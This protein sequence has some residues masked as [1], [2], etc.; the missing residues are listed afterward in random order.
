[1]T[2]KPMP[3]YIL[4]RCN[5]EEQK[6]RKEKKGMFYTA[7]DHQYMVYNMEWGEILAVGERAAKIFPYAKPGM[8][9][10]MHHFVQGKDKWDS[11]AQHLI[12]EDETYYY[13]V[14]TVERY[15]GR[16]NETYGVWDG[17]KIIPHPDFVFLEVEKPADVYADPNDFI[18]AATEKSKG[19]LLLFKEW[20]EGREAKEA[21]IAA[22]KEEI[23]SLSLTGVN[24]PQIA[25][26]IKRL[27]EEMTRISNEMNAVK[28]MPYT[29]MYANP[30]MSEWFDRPIKD[31][32]ILYI[33]ERGAAKMIS[34][35]DKEYRI[36]TCNFVGYIKE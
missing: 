36:G 19:G 20:K 34:F 35:K 12:H 29:V 32:Q 5:I 31:G 7:P 4:V 14:V 33:E 15:M 11:L 3:P 10:I 17:E 27:E 26:Q 18:N 13:Y 30:V 8:T 2:L 9:L 25:A 28:Y 16:R 21:R 24:K 23:D 6:N 22:I 1:M